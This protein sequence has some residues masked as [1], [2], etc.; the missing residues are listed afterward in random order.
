[1]VMVTVTVTVTVLVVVPLSMLLRLRASLLH[2]PAAGAAADC[3]PPA[4]PTPT[5]LFP[6]TL[7]VLNF[8]PSFPFDE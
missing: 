8:L 4:T 6:S 1:M 2:R 3:L 7:I 5:H